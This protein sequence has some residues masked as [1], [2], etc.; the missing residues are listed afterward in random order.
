MRIV[1][2]ITG[3][4]FGGAE[5]SLCSLIEESQLRNRTLKH[6][7]VSILSGGPLRLRL[8]QA[9]ARVIELSGTRGAAGLL[10]MRRL[11]STIAQQNPDIVH[12]WMYHAN[13]ATAVLRRFRY[14]KCPLVW[15]IRQSIDDPTLDRRLTRAI[16]KFGARIS[17]STDLIVYNSYDSALTHIA[18]G[19]SASRY[20]VIHNGINCDRFRPR[21]GAGATLRSQLGLPPDA[22][23]VGRIAR[24]APMKDFATLI[25]AFAKVRSSIPHACL[26]LVGDGIE[27]NNELQSLC[28][29]NGVLDHIRIIN[30][31]LDIEMIYPALDVMVSSSRSNEGFPNVVGEALA[32][33]TLVA[34]SASGDSGLIQGAHEVVPPQDSQALAQAIIKLGRLDAD[35]KSLHASKGRN[36]IVKNFS[37]QQCY[38]SHCELYYSLALQRPID[39]GSSSDVRSGSIKST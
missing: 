24:Y 31:R 39:D 11:A 18:R 29:T 32:S 23:L 5:S 12:A 9:G 1:H 7:V 8:E 26:L 10:A 4:G 28:S 16:I 33:G 27:G 15:S 19:Y 14:F 38:E 35:E 22:L 25:I 6:I 30:P 2:V 20:T 3:L 34:A 21:L 13:V 17:S 37:L 36:F